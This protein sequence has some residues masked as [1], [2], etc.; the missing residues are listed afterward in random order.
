M[1]TLI[2]TQILTQLLLLDVNPNT[3]LAS[4]ADSDDDP[5]YDLD[6]VCMTRS[7][8]SFCLNAFGLK[9]TATPDINYASCVR[10]P[11]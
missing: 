5:G 10:D 7:S 9:V 3:D 6:A 11:V 8:T 1:L 2:L 4:H